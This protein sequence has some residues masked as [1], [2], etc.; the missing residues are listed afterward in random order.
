MIHHNTEN[1]NDA[2]SVKNSSC[3]LL[4]WWWWWFGISMLTDVSIASFVN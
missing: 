4:W 3:H 2:T 1:K